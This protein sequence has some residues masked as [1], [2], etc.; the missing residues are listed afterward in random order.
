MVF[1]VPLWKFQ[2]M[3]EE[4]RVQAVKCIPNDSDRVRVWV[5]ETAHRIQPI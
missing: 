2:E 1:E 5:R 4:G 3:W